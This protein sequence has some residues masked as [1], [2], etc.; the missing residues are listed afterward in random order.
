MAEIRAE[1][2]DDTAFGL[3]ECGREGSN[4]VRRAFDIYV[5]QLG[6]ILRGDGPE[7]GGWLADAGGIENVIGGPM[8]AEHALSPDRNSGRVRDVDR[9]E[10]MRLGVREAQIKDR[11]SAA[12]AADDRVTV[13]NIPFG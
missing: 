12:T 11:C 5:D 2:Y 4:D 10:G 1:I 8:Y 3:D 9:V 6:E 13:G 7:W